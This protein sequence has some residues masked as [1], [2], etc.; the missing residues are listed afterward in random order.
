MYWGPVLTI[1]NLESDNTQNNVI[2]LI[3]TF[4]KYNRGGYLTIYSLIY[5]AMRGMVIF[6]TPTCNKLQAIWPF[7]QINIAAIS[8]ECRSIEST[9]Q[10]RHN[11][12][13]RLECLLNRLFGRRLRNT[14][15]LRVTGLWWGWVGGWGW[16]WGG[17]GWGGGWGVGV[18]GLGWVG[19]NGDRWIPLAKGQ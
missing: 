11:A 19:F 7:P 18:G 4:S 14:S 10:W 6:Q 3:Q 1:S 13:W 8:N 5:S 16:G 9:V 15:K 2:R 12:R 17:V